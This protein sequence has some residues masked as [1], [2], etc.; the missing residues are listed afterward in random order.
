MEQLIVFLNREAVRSFQRKPPRAHP[1]AWSTLLVFHEAGTASRIE[2]V[3]A[4]AVNMDASAA[5][6]SLPYSD[7]RIK[8][9]AGLCIEGDRFADVRPLRLRAATAGHSAEMVL[10]KKPDGD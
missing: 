1:E 9:V 6:C 7:R 3:P 10:A 2:A 8:N 4:A 5:R